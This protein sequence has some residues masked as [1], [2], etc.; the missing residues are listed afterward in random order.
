MQTLSLLKTV[1]TFSNFCLLTA[2]PKQH[3]LH[4]VILEAGKINLMLTFCISITFQPITRGREQWVNEDDLSFQASMALKHI[5]NF[6][7]SLTHLYSSETFQVNQTTVGP[8][9]II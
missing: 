3:L 7:S 1:S 6:M 9:G 8:L 5:A 2:F 4:S